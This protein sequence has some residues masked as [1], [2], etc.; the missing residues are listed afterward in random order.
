MK[1]KLFFEFKANELAKNIL[2]TN[3][4]DENRTQKNSF[5]KLNLLNKAIKTAHS[6]GKKTEL[7]R[8]ASTLKKPIGK[9]L[10]KFISVN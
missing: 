4:D 6:T 2:T 3:N 10:L 9:K 7:I 5:A 1:V 8:A